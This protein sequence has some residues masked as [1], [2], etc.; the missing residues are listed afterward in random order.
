[1]V[2]LQDALVRPRM[3][4]SVG[5]AVT[6]AALNRLTNALAA[7]LA[8]DNIAVVAVD[9]G[10]VQTEVADLFSNAGM[11]MSDGAPM[12][13]PAAAVVEIIAAADPMVFSGRI[14]RAQPQGVGVP[15]TN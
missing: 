10:V 2:P 15:A 6:K 7:D 9:P 13:V 5:Y 1:M 12:T 3:N 8:G 14:V 11:G 4:P